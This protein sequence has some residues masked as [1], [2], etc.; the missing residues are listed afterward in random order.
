MK[1]IAVIGTGVGGAAISALLAKKGFKVQ[2]FE[3]NNFLGGKSAS[4]VRDGFTCDMGIHYTARGDNG[5]LG[6]VS[7]KVSADLQFVKKNPLLRLIWDKKSCDLPI[8]FTGIVPLAKLALTTGVNVKNYL[9]ALKILIKLLSA[10]SIKDVE[11]YYNIPLKE[12]INQYTKDPELHSL[13]ALFCG[14]LI[15]IPI[16]EASTGEFMW[17]FSTWART[18]SCAYP[19]GGFGEIAN[20]YIN[21]L[22]NYNGNLHI[23]EGVK[24]IRVENNRTCGVETNKGFYPADLVISNTGLRRT[25]ELAGAKHFTPDYVEKC[26]SFHDSLGGVTIKYALDFKPTDIPITL[27]CDKGFDF[28]EAFD[29]IDNGQIPKHNPPLFMPCPSIIDPSLAP[30][31]KHILLAGTAVPLS[32]KNK[33]IQDK[34]IDIIDRKVMEVFPGLEDHIIF[35]HTT[36]LNYVTKMSGRHEGDVI[37]LAQSYDQVGENRPTHKTPIKGLFLVGSDA[38]GFGVGTEMAADSALKLDELIS[39]EYYN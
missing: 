4:Y 23:N 32:V 35:K 2:V 34:I 8:K 17:C 31:G 15:T 14:L 10:K 6:E 37:G 26:D 3:R 39:K 25:I 30:P 13:M 18:A 21:A 12:F 5:P 28:N 33:D 1:K 9:A 7:R 27:Y 11:P 36:D 38:G 16:E 19:K 29:A 22:K 24:F 20:S